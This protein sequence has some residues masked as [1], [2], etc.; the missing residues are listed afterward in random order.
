M[1][2]EQDVCCTKAVNRPFLTPA[3]AAQSAA[4]LRERVEAFA[5]RGNGEVVLRITT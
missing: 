1:T 2:S 5:P 3:L 4:G